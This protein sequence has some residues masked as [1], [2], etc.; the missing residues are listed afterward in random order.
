MGN[1]SII[2]FICYLVII[3]GISFIT[4]YIDK[5]KAEMH[6]WRI[7][8]VRLFMLAVL[9]GSIGILSGMKAFR[10][11][12]KHMKFVVGIPCIIIIQAAIIFYVFNFIL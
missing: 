3:N 2:L 6:K 7:S 9:F 5:R 8:E 4:I 11:K 1:W 12:T 10:H